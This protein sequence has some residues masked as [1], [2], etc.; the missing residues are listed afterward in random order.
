MPGNE[1]SKNHTQ[2]FFGCI[3][4]FIIQHVNVLTRLNNGFQPNVHDLV[5]TQETNGA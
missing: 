1:I 3:D 2:S 4:N 5:F